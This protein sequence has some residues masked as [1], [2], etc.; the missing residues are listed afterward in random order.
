M[1]LEIYVH[2]IQIL[3]NSQGLIH[4]ACTSTSEHT[5]AMVYTYCNRNEAVTASVMIW[6]IVSRS[7]WV[8]DCY[9]YDCS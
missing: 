2:N 8:R 7:F 9:R 1:E 3:R 6:L 4:C 5:S